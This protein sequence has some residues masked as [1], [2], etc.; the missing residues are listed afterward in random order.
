MIRGYSRS[1]SPKMNLVQWTYREDDPETVTIARSEAPHEGFV[2]IA[3]NVNITQKT[4]TDTFA[5]PNDNRVYYYMVGGVL[6]DSG[7]YPNPYAKEIVRRDRWFLNSGERHSGAR[8]AKVKIR[9]V[10]GSACPECWDVVHQKVT[11]SKCGTCDG[12][13]LLISFASSLNIKI[14]RS[15]P[16][17]QRIPQPDQINQSVDEQYWTSNFP[18]LKPG[19]LIQT[20]GLIHR[21][22]RVQVTRSEAYIVKQILMAKR[23]EVHRDEYRIVWE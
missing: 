5:T 4:Y 18:L 22:E 3:S 1:L 15:M 23:L 14:A 21:V 7:G 11:K 8:P 2:T 17:L 20:E 9:Y 12:T 16:A 10:D 19:D 13:G 6:L